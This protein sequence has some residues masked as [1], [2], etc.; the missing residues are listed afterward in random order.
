MK[1]KRLNEHLSTFFVHPIIL[2]ALFVTVAFLSNSGLKYLTAFLFLSCCVFL[3]SYLWA[4]GV[5]RQVE[6]SA[7]GNPR[8]CYPGDAV[9][10]S[11]EI[12]NRKWIPMLWLHFIQPA[13]K[14]G[15]VVFPEEMPE[16]TRRFGGIL[17]YGNLR[18]S[19]RYQAARRGIY[20]IENVV[21][22]SG[23]GFGLAQMET[24]LSM[25]KKSEIIVYPTQVP[26]TIDGFLKNLWV[27]SSGKKG[28]VEDTTVMRATRDYEDTDSWK[29]IDWRSAARGGQLQ[30]KLFDTVKPQGVLFVL[31]AACCPKAETENEAFE[32][33]V[34][35]MASL[36]SEL[37]ENRICCGLCLPE[38]QENEAFSQLP[39]SGDAE[40]AEI[41]LAKLAGFEENGA[42]SYYDTDAFRQ[43]LDSSVLVYIFTGEA[44]EPA[45]TSLLEHINANR[46]TV[47]SREEEG[48]YLLG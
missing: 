35:L 4:R 33:T 36:M 7:D 27:G 39:I 15:C 45:C 32:R 12:R 48:R 13:A 20:P 2:A 41:L 14:N 1:S 19:I 44:K 21:I 26:V 47:V 11:Y 10:V 31:D 3:L 17:W 40:L 8:I 22:R 38:T 46:V 43:G 18:F 6:V 29:R 24:E 5:L 16:R 23:D 30:T 9:T 34:S 25:K 37:E 42:V 28:Y